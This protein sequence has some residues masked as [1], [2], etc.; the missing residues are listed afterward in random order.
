MLHYVSPFQKVAIGL[1]SILGWRSLFGVNFPSY[2]VTPALC[3]HL[4][5][6]FRFNKQVDSGQ[7]A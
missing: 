4:V 1:S 6:G 2:N 7:H 5:E 3:A